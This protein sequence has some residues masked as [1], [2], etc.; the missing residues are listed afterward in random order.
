MEW[1]WS[2]SLKGRK[3]EISENGKTI[4]VKNNVDSVAMVDV[5]MSEGK[6]FWK[7]KL[8]NIRD[9]SGLRIGVA[10][11]NLD[12]NSE[13][14]K[15]GFWGIAPGLANK[16]VKGCSKTA[17][18]KKGTSGD[19]VEVELEFVNSKGTLSFSINGESLGV[20]C[21]DLDPPLYPVA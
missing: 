17:W 19:V 3:I 4:N 6:Y 8:D 13:V 21:S 16:I 14:D 20:L 15:K 7:I 12:L 1:V 18:G 2:N 10:E 11:R 9:K 5:P